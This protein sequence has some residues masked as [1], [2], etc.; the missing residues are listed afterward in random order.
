MSEEVINS[1]TTGPVVSVLMAAYNTEKYIG[2]SIQSILSQTYKNFEFIIVDDC[3]TDKTYDIIRRYG[4]ADKRI[5][6]FK[7]KR[8]LGISGNRN[9][10]ISK[11]TGK[12][13]I[14][15]DSDDISTP[16][17]VEKLVNFMEKHLEVGIC[18]SYLQSFDLSG[19]KDVRQYL[20]KDHGLRKNI[21]KLSPVAQPA[22]IIRKKILDQVGKYDL[23]YP[24]AEDLDMSF[25]I[26]S[27]SAFANVPQVLLKYRE[28]SSSNSTKKIKVVIKNTLAIRQKYSNNLGYKMTF[29]DKIAFC[30][31]WVVQFIPPIYAIQVF[32]LLKESLQKT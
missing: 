8:N 19:P 16:D 30:L 5:K 24:P 29:S 6:H 23:R 25:R 12:Y 13:I 21:F 31:T 27:I 14:W 28:H 18:G 15:Q 11:A 1:T 26:G 2:E 17:R 4:A 22:A 7:N 32:K 9:F 10:L 20:T 3:S